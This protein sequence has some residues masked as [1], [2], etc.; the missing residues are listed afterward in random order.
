[1][2]QQAPPYDRTN[3]E[4]AKR[5]IERDAHDLKETAKEQA[6]GRA[7]Q[8]KDR[9]ASGARS[10]SSAIQTAADEMRNDGDTPDWLASAFSSAAR[11]VDDVARRVQ[12]KSPRELAGETRR[13]ARDNPTAFLAASAA[14]GFAAARFLRAGAEEHEDIPVGSN[15]RQSRNQGFDEPLQT[16]MSQRVDDRDDDWGR[17]A[18]G[19]TAPDR[20]AATPVGGTP[21]VKTP[22]GSR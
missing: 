18:I 3:P 12:D 22:G 1:M 13:F 19:T 9:I 16:R 5:D 17:G 8:E 7:R 11:Q 10:A 20:P 15:T 4:G 21:S 14:V 2:T 6:A